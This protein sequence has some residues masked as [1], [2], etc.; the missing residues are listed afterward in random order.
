[1]RCKWYFYFPN[2][3]LQCCTCVF[4]IAKLLGAK[5]VVGICGSDKKCSYLKQHCGF[6]ATVNYKTDNVAEK[7]KQTCPSGIH[8][9]FDNVGGKLSETV[10][11]HVSMKKP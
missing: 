1:M 3:F 11:E 4:Q 8:G 6:D 5:Q 10:I 2:S 7:L 9:Y